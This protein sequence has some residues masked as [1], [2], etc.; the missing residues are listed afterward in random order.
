MFISLFANGQNRDKIDP[1]QLYGPYGSEV[2]T[3]YTQAQLKPNQV[4][5]LKLIDQ[6]LSKSLKRIKR[7][8]KLYVI[9]LKNNHI[10]SFPEEIT[11]FKNLMYLKS[12]GNP[13]KKLPENIGNAPTLKNLILHHVELD[14]LPSNFNRL[15]SL[16]EI[17]IQI[18]N[19]DTLKI[20]NAFSGIF[21]LK[22]IMLYKCNLDTFPL[23]LDKNTKLKKVIMVDCKLT[24]LTPTLG[25]NNSIEVLVLDKNNFKEFPK[26]LINH[27]TIKD[28]SLRNNKITHLPESVSK[29]KSLEI[30][31]LS[32]NNIPQIE[33]EIVQAL[34]PGCKIIH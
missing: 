4:F 14:S 3:N 6:D 5:R 10:D 23:G 30:L 13:I 17:E 16:T 1:F 7:L 33:I 15:N 12:A 25:N 8:H 22:S 21:N 24:S 19:S 9:E 20:G 27:K 34:L 18:N 11:T 31:D 29:M 26:E 2:F 28:L 32:G